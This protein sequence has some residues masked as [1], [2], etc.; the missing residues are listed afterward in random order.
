MRERV[1]S[2]VHAAD[3]A[4]AASLQEHQ[5]TSADLRDGIS[6]ATRTSQDTGELVA[7]LQHSVARLDGTLSEMQ[8]D[9][10]PRV[11]AVVAEKSCGR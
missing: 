10:R 6:R 8:H 5:A 9:W 11:D 1:A 2:S 4:M 7:G 3:E